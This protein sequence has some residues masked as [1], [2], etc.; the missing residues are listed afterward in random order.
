MTTFP[1]VQTLVISDVG[2]D[3]IVH[4]TERSDI[5]V[6]SDS[7]LAHL[8]PRGNEFPIRDIGGSLRLFVP[9]ETRI[10]AKDIGGDAQIED[11]L[12][13]ELKDVGGDLVI[14]N[15]TAT[16]QFKNVGGDARLTGLRGGFTAK[17]VG[18]DLYLSAEQIT[19]RS[20]INVGG[21]ATVTIPNGANLL[22]VATV[23]GDITGH[24]VGAMS[25][26]PH[27]HILN[28]TYGDGTAYLELFV[29]G[30]LVVNGDESPRS[31]SSSSSNTPNFEREM[32]S[33]GRNISESVSKLNVRIN[34]REWQ[35]DP[36]RLDRL[37]EQAKQAAN[38][39]VQGALEAVEQAL[40]NIRMPAPKTAPKPPV[41]PAPP[42]APLETMDALQPM[43]PMQPMQPMRPMTPME[44]MRPMQPLEWGKE[45]QKQEQRQT[46]IASEM[47]VPLP[48]DPVQERRAI[49]RMIAEGRITP[50]EGDLLLEALGN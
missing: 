47:V 44:P 41:P 24:A 28:L 4:G 46:Q 26:E 29:G 19:G 37:V 11:V 15:V 42:V 49:L 22:L 48:S 14:K 43:A 32:G 31:S 6:Q 13:V 34:E 50:D 18:G 17:D 20:S 12:S 3:L 35:L 7:D 5:E 38:D 2:G 1:A 25:S 39:G 8:Q 30:D 40:N 33:V 23:G 36:S 27:T 45:S 16:A 9:H 21:D 10:V